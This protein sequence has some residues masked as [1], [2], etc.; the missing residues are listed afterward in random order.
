MD[1][2]LNTI[3]NSKID[4]NGLV[5]YSHMVLGY[6]W[7]RRADSAHVRRTMKMTLA[8]RNGGSMIMIHH[9][10]RG[11]IYIS[12]TYMGLLDTQNIRASFSRLAPNAIP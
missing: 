12:K 2:L 1:T 8:G 3:S 4:E 10:D 6:S 9:S 5:N 11:S 7:S